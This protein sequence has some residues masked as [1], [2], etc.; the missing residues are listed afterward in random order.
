MIYNYVIKILTLLTQGGHDM[1]KIG[2]A[3]CST[4]DQNPARQEALLKEKGCEKIYLDMLS[5]KDT[6][7]PQLQAMMEYIREGDTVYV[8]SISRLARSTKDLLNLVE[9]FNNK[10][11]SFVSQKEAI[12]TT[13]PQGRFML[14]VFAAMAELERE[15]IKQRQAEG[16]AIAKQQGKYQ[17]RQPIYYDKYTFSKLYNDWKDGM[18]TQKHMCKVLGVSRSTLHRIIQKEEYNKAAEKPNENK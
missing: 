15:Q 2:Y 11:V 12:D 5:G 18:I 10:G 16:I 17:G 1:S 14:T 6:K 8:E 9:Q 4:A 3:R 13:T 7:R